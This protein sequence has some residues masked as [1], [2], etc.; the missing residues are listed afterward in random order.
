MKGGGTHGA[1]L[2]AGLQHPWADVA[3]AEGM[4]EHQ[5]NLVFSENV[6]LSSSIIKVRAGTEQA[7]PWVLIYIDALMMYPCCVPGAEAAR[8]RQGLPRCPL[9]VLPAAGGHGEF[10]ERRRSFSPK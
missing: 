2:R 8:G 7:A 6:V 5:E 3:A 10:P 9:Q 1:V 4:C